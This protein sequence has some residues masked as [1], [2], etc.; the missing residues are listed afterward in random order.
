MLSWDDFNSEEAKKT[1]VTESAKT[2]GAMHQSAV[3]K[4]DAIPPK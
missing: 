4:E 1:T 3:A 2:Q